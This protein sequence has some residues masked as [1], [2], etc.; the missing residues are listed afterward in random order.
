M[1]DEDVKASSVQTTRPLLFVE[2]V[3]Q[4]DPRIR[5]AVLSTLHSSATDRVMESQLMRQRMSI[6]RGL[7]Q[8]S[9]F[10]SA[11]LDLPADLSM[12][13]SPGSAGFRDFA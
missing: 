3:G 6:L 7:L 12:C 1:S 2:N 10:P 5:F 11:D 4:F 9:A 8:R 13:S